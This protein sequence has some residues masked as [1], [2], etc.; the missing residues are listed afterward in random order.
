[1][2][3]LFTIFQNSLA[4]VF[5]DLWW[6]AGILVATQKLANPVVKTPDFISL[7]QDDSYDIVV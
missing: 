6:L 3:I 4:E 1:M 5:K 2:C 7:D